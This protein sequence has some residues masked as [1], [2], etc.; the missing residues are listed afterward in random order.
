MKQKDFEALLKH[1]GMMYPPG[2]FQL[3]L[4]LL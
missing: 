3:E 4:E 2:P 1:N